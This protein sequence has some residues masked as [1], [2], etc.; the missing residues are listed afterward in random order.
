TAATSTMHR[1]S[2]QV[3][4]SLL[5]GYQA[6]QHRQQKCKSTNVPWASTPPSNHP[7]GPTK[8]ANPPRCRG[9]LK[10]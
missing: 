9:K 2:K 8:P 1:D 4:T 5:A 10:S 7:R 3:E 6:N